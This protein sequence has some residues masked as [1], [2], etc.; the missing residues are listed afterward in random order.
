MYFHGPF[1]P[2]LEILFRD[3]IEKFS[4]TVNLPKKK[5]KLTIFL[6]TPGGNIESVDKLVNIIRNNF[7]EV[8]FVIPD[9]AMSAGTIFCMS[10][11]K[12][13]M[14]YTSS[15]GPID[16]QVYNGTQWVPA[17]GYIDK[18]EELIVKINNNSNARAEFLLL[19]RQD[20]ATLKSYE[21]ARDLSITLLKE[22]LVNY[23]FSDWNIHRTDLAKLNQPV[24]FQE[25]EERAEKIAKDLCDYTIWKSH[26]RFIGLR[27]LIDVLRLEIEDYSSNKEL[28]ELIRTY[29]DLLL[30]YI[31][32]SDSPF[33]F[34]TKYLF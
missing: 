25:K 15:L 6:N 19:Q 5:D 14:D 3:I 23:K 30:D 9:S 26:G 33:F 1:Q 32:K 22:W 29:N 2:G 20:L 17:L 11:N 18:V 7:K 34:H 13:Y 12:V 4:L 31:R 16:P 27:T 8:N 28:R 21:Q 10:G 24:T